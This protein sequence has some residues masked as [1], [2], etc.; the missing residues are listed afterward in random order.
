MAETVTYGDDIV[1]EA[2]WARGGTLHCDCHR[3]RVRLSSED[4]DDSTL[5]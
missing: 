5:A 1:S 3:N 2:R 4:E